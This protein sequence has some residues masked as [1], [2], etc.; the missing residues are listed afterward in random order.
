MLWEGYS[1]LLG[2]VGIVAL[3]NADT[4]ASIYPSMWDIEYK[5]L[6]I[7]DALSASP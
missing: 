5:L 2:S 6:E 1:L 7:G 4:P 3:V